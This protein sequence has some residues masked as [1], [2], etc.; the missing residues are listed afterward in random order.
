MY[1]YICFFSLHAMCVSVSGEHFTVTEVKNIH[2]HTH[3]A[4]AKTQNSPHAVESQLFKVFHGV[5]SITCGYSQVMHCEPEL[6][7]LKQQ[8]SV[9]LLLAI[10]MLYGSPG[11]FI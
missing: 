8:E 1:V 4:D 7:D 10:L 3:P 6:T 11:R 2:R 9:S 5:K